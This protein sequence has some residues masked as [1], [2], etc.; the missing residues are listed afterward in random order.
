MTKGLWPLTLSLR[1][2]IISSL[3]LASLLRHSEFFTKELHTQ[4]SKEFKGIASSP[5]HLPFP[6]IFSILV[7]VNLMEIIFRVEE[8][9]SVMESGRKEET[10]TIPPPRK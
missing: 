5:V 3:L 2:Q 1:Q 8:I 7:V 10:V 4:N 6:I 9:E